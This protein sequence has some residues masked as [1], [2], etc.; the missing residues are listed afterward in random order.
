MKDLLEL[1]DEIDEIDSAI[2][3]LFEKRMAISEAVAEFKISTG[4]KVFDKDRERSKL[5]KLTALAHNDFNRHGVE[6][7]FQQIMSM[8]RKKQYQLLAQNGVMGRLPFISVDALDTKNVR[9]V[10][11]GVEGAYSHAAMRRFFGEDVNCFHVD[12]WRD[13]MEAIAEGAADYAVLPIENSSAGI[14]AD[15]FDLLVDFENYIVGEQ[16]IRCEHVLMGMPGTKPEEISTV[17]SHQQALS[18]CEQ[19][20]NEH[21]DWKQIPYDN[22]AMAAR[23][24]SE[25]QD[26]SQAAIGSAFAAQLFGLEILA[27]HIYYNE[28]NSTRFIIVTN[29]RIFRKDAGKISICFELP[30]RSGSLYNMLSHFIYNNLNMNRIESRPITGRNWEY[31]FFVDF[32]GNLNDSSVKN[33]LRGIREEAINMKILGNY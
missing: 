19:F 14:V 3:D 22:T 2:V 29:Q 33:A 26:K 11:Q 23:K 18:Q 15:N 10:Y 5:E 4:K 7:L 12:R 16:V 25:D 1:R 17:Y 27:D 31:R 8:S 6:E 21:R 30:H 13:A 32:D 9:V 24:V 20:L 28:A